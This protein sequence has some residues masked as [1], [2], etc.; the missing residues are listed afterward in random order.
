MADSS[1]SNCSLVVRP[2]SVERGAREMELHNE[3]Q[4][5]KEVVKLQILIAAGRTAHI[6]YKTQ[7][8]VGASL[9]NDLQAQGPEHTPWLKSVASLVNHAQ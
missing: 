1:G 2:A 3:N 4:L 9:G 6:T 7:I 8:R 5:Y